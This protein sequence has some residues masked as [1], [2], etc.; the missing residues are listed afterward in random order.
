MNQA[1]LDNFSAHALNNLRGGM[2]GQG[3]IDF[4]NALGQ[5]IGSFF[6]NAQAASDPTSAVNAGNYFQNFA[7]QNALFGQQQG[8]NMLGA[9]QQFGMNPAG[10]N[11]GIAQQANQLGLASLNN[12][13]F[14]QLAAD[15]VA[16]MRTLARPAE[17][18][19][20][21]SKFQNLFNRGTLSATSGERQ[22]GELAQAQEFAD[23]A[24]IDAAEKF[25]QGLA[26]QNQRFGLNALGTGLAARGQ[27]ANFNAQMASMFGN[28]GQGMLN[29]G[30]GAG[31][32]QFN[33]AAGMNE[34]INSRGQQRL[35]NAQSLMGF[36]GGLYNQGI[37]Q[38]LGLFGGTRGINADL[39]S[40]IGLSL[41]G[42][43]MRAQAGARQGGFHMQGAISPM[44]SLLGSVGSGLA[45]SYGG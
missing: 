1:F 32:T 15:Q 28:L 45:S 8:M 21:N 4:G 31:Q 20:V 5:N 17:E 19:A 14:S 38:T 13:D 2:F 12:T 3:A 7:V 42:G 41:Q 24:R 23:I 33:T 18:Q 29:F 22:I 39:R 43:D 40:L 30:Q 36:G 6:N 34:L 37:D 27:D 25:A 9:A 35:A 44:G 10:V 11:E 26:A 16:R